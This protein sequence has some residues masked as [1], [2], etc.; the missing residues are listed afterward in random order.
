MREGGGVDIPGRSVR[1]DQLPRGQLCATVNWDGIR[2]L[3][4]QVNVARP[5]W[6]MRASE[7]I[8]WHRAAGL[9][10]RASY[11][12]GWLVRPVL[13]GSIFQQLDVSCN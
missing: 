9:E 4:S 5:Q 13:S 10:H 7:N 2:Y 11:P 8:A 1:L 12:A 3:R 6:L